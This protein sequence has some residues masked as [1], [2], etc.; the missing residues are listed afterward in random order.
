M[1]CAYVSFEYGNRWV[2]D[3]ICAHA[4][5]KSEKGRAVC[6]R[7]AEGKM[8]EPGESKATKEHYLWKLHVYVGR[9]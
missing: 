9:K 4:M 5:G 8:A 7:A 1:L 6:A 2:W 3:T